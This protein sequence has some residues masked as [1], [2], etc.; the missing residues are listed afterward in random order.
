MHDERLEILQDRQ[1]VHQFGDNAHERRQLLRCHQ[2]GD[3]H[4]ALGVHVPLGRTS[5]GFSE[6]RGLQHLLDSSHDLWLSQRTCEIRPWDLRFRLRFGDGRDLNSRS[7]LRSTSGF[8][9]G[10]GAVLGR[11]DQA[12]NFA[13]SGLEQVLDLEIGP[14]GDEVVVLIAVLDVAVLDANKGAQSLFELGER[15]RL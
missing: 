4:V 11:H 12:Q 10:D 8:G 9:N 14:D 15:R 2:C 13:L 6:D 3:N 5:D 1:L 7:G